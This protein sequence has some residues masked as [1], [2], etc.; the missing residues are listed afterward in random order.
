MSAVTLCDYCQGVMK[1]RRFFIIPKKC[2]VC[3]GKHRITYR[4]DGDTYHPAPY[5]GG[6]PL[7][8]KPHHPRPI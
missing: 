4:K 2:P 5:T 8:P 3:K 6:E 7:E 1:F